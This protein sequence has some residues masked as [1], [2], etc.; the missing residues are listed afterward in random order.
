MTKNL[1][2][3]DKTVETMLLATKLENG[4][5]KNK[6]NIQLDHGYFKQQPYDF[7]LDKE[8]LPENYLNYINQ[9]YLTIKDSRKVFYANFFL[10]T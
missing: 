9:G 2:F 5:R 3:P 8:N 7:D 10:I 1:A 4:N 6:T